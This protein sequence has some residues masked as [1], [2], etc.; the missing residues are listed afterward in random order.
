MNVGEL[1]NELKK[2]PSDMLVVKVV[3]FENCDEYGNVKTEPIYN[4][5]T[6]TYVDL[7]FGD[8]DETELMIY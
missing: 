7:Q 3:D 6:Q 4:V 1:I 2:Y 5:Q 8:D